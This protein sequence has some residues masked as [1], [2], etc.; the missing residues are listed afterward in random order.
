MNILI[1]GDSITSGAWDSESGWAHRLKKDFDKKVIESKFE[2]YNTVYPLGISGNTSSHLINRYEKELLSRF[3]PEDKNI[4]IVSI[5]INDTLFNNETKTH[6]IPIDIFEENLKKISTL[7]KTHDTKLIIVG[8]TPSD[9][10]V[11]PV[12]WMPSSSYRQKDIVEYEK[13]I[14]EVT[15]SLNIPFIE[16]MSNFD[17]PSKLLS[18]GIHPNTEGH[19]LIF[20]LVKKYLESK[21]FSNHQP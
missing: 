17:S 5:G 13:R 4:S 21:V 8:L 20:E 16:L 10:R 19:K 12:P 18:D 1:F 2:E 7:S 3:D 11:D 15:K 14:K 6:W 9:K